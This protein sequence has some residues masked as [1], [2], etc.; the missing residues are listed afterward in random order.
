MTTYIYKS[1]LAIQLIFA[2]LVLSNCAKDEVDTM[3]DIHGTVSDESGTPIQTASVTLTPTGKTTTTGSDGRYEFN[4]LDPQQYTVSVT[5]SDYSSDFKS[6]IVRAGET[7]K[8][9]LV[10]KR[11]QAQL[12]VNVTELIFGDTDNLLSFEITNTGSG[13]LEWQIKEEAEWISV[14]PSHGK[15][16]K[17]ISSVSVRINRAGLSPNVEHTYTLNVTSTNGGTKE[18]KVRVRAQTALV[19]HP[20]Q[21]DFGGSLSEMVFTLNNGA[22]TAMIAFTLLPSEPWIKVSPATGEITNKGTSIKVTIDRT[23]LP[24]GKKSGQIEIKSEQTADLMI[25]VSMEVNGGRLSVT[26]EALDF[27]TNKTEEYLTI[28]KESGA[29]A[30]SYTLSA[31][32][33]WISFEKTAGTVDAEEEN[34]KVSVSRIGLEPGEHTANITVKGSGANNVVI[35]VKISVSSSGGGNQNV[36]SCDSRIPIEVLSCKRNGTTLV[37]TYKLTN[38]GMGKDLTAFYIHPNNPSN[39]NSF[40]DNLGNAYIATGNSSSPVTLVAGGKSSYNT[41]ISIALPLNAPVQGSITIKDFNTEATGFNAKIYCSS[42][43]EYTLAN[44]WITFKDI[45]IQ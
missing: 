44:N 24:V 29:S 30:I 22:G 15:T 38:T 17:E 33:T 27:S 23:A 45:N 18:V 43:S 39:L 10:L 2:L 21:L 16:A 32:Q 4:D 3:G 1:L 31:N 7:S 12:K 6:V 25:P 11:G 9:D 28:K 13:I 8:G 37:L 41:A 20:T 42:P 5:K 14:E 40:S 36:T 26:P 34:V 35:P 19:V